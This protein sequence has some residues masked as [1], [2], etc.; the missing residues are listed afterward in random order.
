MDKNITADGYYV[1]FVY[2]WNPHFLNTLKFEKFDP[3]KIIVNDYDIKWITAG[4]IF[5][6]YGDDFKFM[7]NY[8]IKMEFEKQVK[9]DVLLIR[10]QYLIHYPKTRLGNS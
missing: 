8:V 1:Q 10:L 2:E 5:P 9:N 4:L 3:D 6:I 7:I